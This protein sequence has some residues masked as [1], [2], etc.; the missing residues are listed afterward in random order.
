MNDD[1]PP[2]LTPLGIWLIALGKHNRVYN[3][4]MGTFFGVSSSA[5][6]GAHRRHVL[7]LGDTRTHSTRMRARARPTGPEPQPGRNWD[8]ELVEPWVKFTARK[9][10]ERAKAKE[11][12]HV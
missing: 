1:L 7:G 12:E 9:Q 2:H 3:S 6:A 8:S 4:D 11:R 10:A 5:I